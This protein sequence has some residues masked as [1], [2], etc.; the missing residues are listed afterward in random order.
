MPIQEHF[1]LESTSYQAAN[2]FQ[3][4]QTRC[5][6]QHW[7]QS[8]VKAHLFGRPVVIISAPSPEYMCGLQSWLHSNIL[9]RNETIGTQINSLARLILLLQCLA[10]RIG[11]GLRIRISLRDS[12]GQPCLLWTFKSW[13]G[14]GVLGIATDCSGIGPAIIVVLFDFFCLLSHLLGSFPTKQL[15]KMAKVQVNF[16][17]GTEKNHKAQD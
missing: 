4:F 7:M 13:L 12:F 8:R 1:A 14:S 2:D 6:L 15:A 17:T 10:L 11:S 16:S 9:C 3:F 5:S